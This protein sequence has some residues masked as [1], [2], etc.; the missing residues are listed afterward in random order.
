MDVEHL[1]SALEPAPVPPDP[2]PPPI[3]T[4]SHPTKRKIFETNQITQS[5]HTPNK[6][7]ASPDLSVPSIQTVYTDPSIVIGAIQSY[8]SSDKGPYVVHVSRTDPDQSMGT[9]L[10]TIKFG[11]FLHKNKFEN[12][13]PGGVKQV[14]RNKIS[15]VFSSAKDA[16]SFVTSSILSMHKLHAVIPTYNVT[17]MGLIR[18]VPTDLSMEEFAEAASNPVGAKILKARRLNRKNIDEGKVT[19]VP[20]QTVVVTFQGQILPSRV[21]LFYNSIP[22]EIYQFPTIQCNSCCRFGHTKAQCRSKPRCFRCGQEHTG[23]GCVV[24]ETEASCLHCSGKHFAT[25]KNCPEL[26]RQKS[27]KSVM[28]TNAVSYEE[29]ASQF[30]RVSRSYS[31]IAQ[32]LFSPSQ[33]LFYPSQD[34]MLSPSPSYN[35]T[36][37]IPKGQKP[38]FKTVLSSP[39]SRAPLGKSYDTASHREIVSNPPSSLPNG[40]GLKAAQVLPQSESILDSL[41]TLLINLIISNPQNLP[42][43]VAA[44]LTQLVSLSGFQ[45]GSCDRSAVELPEH[46]CETS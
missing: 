17:R 42:S 21:F 35:L 24:S 23:D 34:I 39:R 10:R 11:Q 30:P 12:I 9:T 32:E 44:K 15:V 31:E 25:S 45:H 3:L 28:A 20:T 16:N 40:C 43:N 6:K 18:N 29:A 46:S 7:V 4:E 41:L 2:V 26:A 19:W 13:I 14:G 38:H 27:I 1:V 5:A 36:S 22:V 8:N 37:N 33:D